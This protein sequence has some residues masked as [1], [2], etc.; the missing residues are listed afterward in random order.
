MSE[1]L[2]KTLTLSDAIR[3]SKPLRFN[4]MFKPIGPVCNLNC[5]YC[6]YLDK[7][8]MYESH[9]RMPLELLEKIIKEYIETNDSEQIVFD[10]HGGEPLLLGL[11]YFKRIVDIQN[12]YRGNKNIFNT[13]QTN[14]TLLDHDFADFFKDYNFLVGVSLDG[15]QDVHDECRKDK[16]GRPSFMKVMKGVELLHRYGVDFNTL[17]T[18]NKAS[19]GKGLEVYKFMKNI[20]SHYMQF[21]PVYEYI[22]PLNKNI[23]SPDTENS[24]L[25]PWSVSPMEYG[26]FMC[27]IF[28]Y[29]VKNDVGDYFVNLFDSTLANYCGVNPGTCI[30]S[31]T[32]GANAVLEHNGDI[33]PCDHF[34]YPYYK[35]GNIKDMSLKDMVSSEKM[36]EFG[37]NK[38][39]TLPERCLRCKFYFAC[40]GECPKHRFAKT[41][42]NES[43]LNSL[44]DGLFYFFS[45]AEPYMLKMKEFLFEGKEAKLIMKCE[46][47]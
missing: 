1:L 33:Y 14:A 3:I 40:R 35:L 32:C 30:Y 13:I 12:K 45:Y 20:G 42:Q 16:N 2:D 31:E 41:S 47:L 8:D 25:A 24:V 27:D 15:P 17:T 39:N 46:S 21:M 38:R 19:E 5:T 10:W 6:Y 9:Q 34:V 22:N 4:M 7:N 36:I 37:I 44:C 11:D 43:G 26:K 28:D 29:W 18:I 23:V